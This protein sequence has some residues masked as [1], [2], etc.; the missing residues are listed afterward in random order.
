AVSGALFATPGPRPKPTSPIPPTKIIAAPQA[1][2]WKLPSRHAICASRTP[3]PQPVAA[4][5]TFAARSS[6]SPIAGVLD[7]PPAP[8]E[9]R[10]K[11]RFLAN[12]APTRVGA[13]EE[14]RARRAGPLH[15]S[16]RLALA[17]V[18]GSRAAAREP[19]RAAAGGTSRG[20]APRAPTRSPA[21]RR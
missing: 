10:S 21:A 4:N 13:A 15:R 17:F 5:S 3:A 16:Q 9:G 19:A 1:W 2:S 12:A 7:R 11:A 8:L 6:V 18:R 20:S 14:D